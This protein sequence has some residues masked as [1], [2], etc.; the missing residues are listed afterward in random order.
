MS[1]VLSAKDLFAEMKRMP[2]AERAKFFSL[3]TSSAFGQDRRVVGSGRIEIERQADAACRER[4]HCSENSPNPQANDEPRC[5]PAA[6]PTD[7]PVALGS[8][9]SSNR[10]GA[11][12]FI[13]A[14][15]N[16]VELSGSL[17]AASVTDAVGRHVAARL[18]R[19]G[20]A[21]TLMTVR[22]LDL[23]F[24]DPAKVSEVIGV[25]PSHELR[26]Q[27]DLEAIAGVVAV[28]GVQPHVGQAGAP[29]AG[30]F[31]LNGT[32]AS[33]CPPLLGVPGRVDVCIVPC[34]PPESC[35]GGMTLRMR[36]RR[37]NNSDDDDHR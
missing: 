10:T 35:V 2:T 9:G 36:R 31:N 3:L 5:A 17:R 12:Q 34:D 30:F 37:V 21:T 14:R 32:M 1:Q 20:V 13:G 15:V 23:P 4:R 25:D 27:A 28:A 22:D 19:A 7:R 6:R 33:A 11:A 18:R 16:D 26:A 29:S 8:A 24:Y